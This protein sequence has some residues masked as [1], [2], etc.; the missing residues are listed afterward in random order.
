MDAGSG[1]EEVLSPELFW[2]LTRTSWILGKMAGLPPNAAD[3]LP[4]FK[5]IG[6]SLKKYV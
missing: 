4:H 3:F 2:Q 1:R 6:Q 5:A